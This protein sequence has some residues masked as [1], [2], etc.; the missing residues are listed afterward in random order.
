MSKD[1]MGYSA[2]TVPQGSRVVLIVSTGEPVRST[3][4]V[5]MP[6]IIG[7]SQGAAL[8]E[9]S[10]TSLQAQVVYDYHPLNKKGT[11]TATRP[12]PGTNA[13]AGTDALVL[14]SSGEPMGP[15]AIAAL[16]MV[17]GLD[18]ASALADV[19][20]AGLNA[21]VMYEASSTVPAGYVID[22]LPNQSTYVNMDK[23]SG[24]A[25]PWAYVAAALAVMTLALLGFF[26]LGGMDLFAREKV[27][28]PDVVGMTE[29]Q[30]V[31]ALDEVGLVVGT[32]SD[33]EATAEISTPGAVIASKPEAGE[34]VAKG[35]KVNLD[36]VIDPSK[37]RA[38]VPKVIGKTAEDATAELQAAGFVVASEYMVTNQFAAGIVAEQSPAGGTRSHKDAQVTIRISSGPA[39]DIVVPDVVGLSE[40]A[41][42]KLLTNVGLTFS[43]T[44]SPSDWAA[45]GSVLSSSPAAGVQVTPGTNVALVVSSGPTP[46]PT[47]T[48]PNYV[49]WNSMD[50]QRNLAE[51][52]LVGTL[53]PTG[54]DG[55]VTSTDPE[56]GTAVRPGSTV[57][58]YVKETPIVGY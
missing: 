6:D 55:Q 53:N 24:K 3:S 33:K 19:R 23:K 18:E 27:E 51:L 47:V 10:K 5:T 31:A 37:V 7:K 42:Q 17:T 38:D 46:D 36:V 25:K 30:A 16:P 56:A 39:A 26:M 12:A 28:V 8:E 40:D 15:R 57:T 52:G 2:T 20:Q 45:A 50:A 32:I 43:S 48:I 41:A 1:T 14:V 34:E 35:S 49:G 13:I 29:E 21:Q 44:T 9:I 11:V 4:F 58:I 22:Q 54:A